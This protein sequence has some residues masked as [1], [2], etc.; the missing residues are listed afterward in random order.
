[1]LVDGQYPWEGSCCV[2]LK[3]DINKNISGQKED[4]KD[5]SKAINKLEQHFEKIS[6]QPF[7]H[8]I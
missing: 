5:N 8:N 1:M 4:G 2:Y 7:V 6:W 3:A